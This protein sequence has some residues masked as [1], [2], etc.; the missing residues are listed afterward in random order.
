VSAIVDESDDVV[1]VELVRPLSLHF[2][3]LTLLRRRAEVRGRTAK[4][5]ANSWDPTWGL[6]LS[7]SA[8]G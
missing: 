5:V 4:G 7:K 6:N 8:T 3:R 2:T 1:D